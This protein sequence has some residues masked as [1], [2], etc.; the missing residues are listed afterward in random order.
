MKY[1]VNNK[2]YS[3]KIFWEYI[4]LQDAVEI[5]KI[6]IAADDFLKLMDK[7]FDEI[8]DNDREYIIEV[9]RILSTTPKT[10]LEKIKPEYLFLL[11]AEVKDKV[12]GL[13]NFN[14]E[15]YKPL[16]FEGFNFK[17]KYYKLPKYIVIDDKPVLCYNE[18]SKNIIEALNIAQVMSTLKNE[19]ISYMRY[20]CA[21]YLKEEDEEFYDEEKITK[22]AEL[23]KTLPMSIVLEC[24]FFI[25]IFGNLLITNSLLFSL[26]RR[27][28][29]KLMKVLYLILGSISL[30]IHKLQALFKKS[31]DSVYGSYSNYLNSLLIK[32]I[33]KGRNLKK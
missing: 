12:N 29:E 23:F 28:K 14:F 22:R 26:K 20:L 30:L 31:K 21:I 5:S 8:D 4:T 19:G 6:K 11:W 7:E 33:R 32:T 24:F 10:I 15:S 2:T 9:L 17:G 18:P 25:Y 3:L 13:F 27:R 16:G 1:K